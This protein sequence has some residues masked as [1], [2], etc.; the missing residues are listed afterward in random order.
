MREVPFDLLVQR[1]RVARDLGRT[2]LVRS[3]LVLQA[4][5]DA[6]LALDGLEVEGLAVDRGTSKLDLLLDLERQGDRLAGFLEYSAELFEPRT[7]EVLL[8]RFESVL[9]ALAAGPGIGL[10]ELRARLD[11]LHPL[12]AETLA[13]P[14]PGRA[15]RRAVPLTGQDNG[16]G[17]P[18][19]S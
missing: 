15:R 7:V 11:A 5:D 3:N 10:G 1:L 4:G 12:T 2:P 16:A 6:G 19:T 18:R 14:G 9:A 8:G 13:S 17:A